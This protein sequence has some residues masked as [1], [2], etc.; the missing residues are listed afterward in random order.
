MP[1][2]IV[3]LTNNDMLCGATEIEHSSYKAMY[4]VENDTAF[5]T[6]VMPQLPR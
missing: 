3:I 6:A 2:V 1:I 4:K 5:A